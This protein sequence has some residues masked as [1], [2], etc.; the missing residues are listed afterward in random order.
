MTDERFAAIMEEAKKHLGK[1]YVF[2]ASGPSSFDCSGFVCYV[3]NHSGVK[4]VGRTTAQGLYNL[5][6]PVSEDNAKPGDL[7]FFKGTY[8]T[9]ATVTH[10]GIYIGNGMMINAGD[11]VKY[12]DITTSYWQQHFYAFARI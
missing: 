7:I 10:V 8:S 1:P 5:C 9:S 4:N 3:L 6:T 2:G 12:A 11:P